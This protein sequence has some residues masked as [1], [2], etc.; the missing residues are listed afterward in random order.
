[1]NYWQNW[2]YDGPHNWLTPNSHLTIS[3]S[4]KILLTCC[5]HSDEIFVH[6]IGP[7]SNWFDFVSLHISQTHQHFLSLEGTISLWA[8]MLDSFQHLQQW[9]AIRLVIMFMIRAFSS[10]GLII[11]ADVHITIGLFFCIRILDTCMISILPCT[12]WRSLNKQVKF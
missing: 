11:Y 10:L 6:I 1:M 3:N 5:M 4:N 2:Y 8:I 7:V 12:Y 9:A